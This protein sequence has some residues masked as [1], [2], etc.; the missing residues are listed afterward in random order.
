[1]CAGWASDVASVCGREGRERVVALSAGPSL[2]SSLREASS[3]PE[4]DTTQITPQLATR[5]ARARSFV[6]GRKLLRTRLKRWLEEEGTRAAGAAAA[7]AARGKP[8]PMSLARTFS[9]IDAAIARHGF[10]VGRWCA[11]PSLAPVA[12]GD[13]TRLRRASV[14]TRLRR[15]TEVV[16]PENEPGR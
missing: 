13:G 8:Q 1:V 9:K 6:L 7:A 14:N 4:G 16:R 10:K 15:S 5:A 2:E 11:R 3:S 12:E